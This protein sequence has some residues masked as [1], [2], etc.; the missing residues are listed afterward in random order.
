MMTLLLATTIP[1]AYVA[2]VVVAARFWYQRIR[3]AKAYVCGR[4]AFAPHLIDGKVHTVSKS[5]NEFNTG[6]FAQCYVRWGGVRD[7]GSAAWFALCFGAA[8]LPVMLGWGLVKAITRG[9]PELE[10]ER[11]AR[12]R[13]LKAEND[14]MERELL[15]GG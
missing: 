5:D 11:A 7:D 9:A 6:H 12:L 4:D 15:R 14:R 2:G 10:E 3:P 8:W 1:A 13:K